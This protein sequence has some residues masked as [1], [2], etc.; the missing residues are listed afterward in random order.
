MQYA[1]ELPEE[2]SPTTPSEFRQFC[3]RSA[4]QKIGKNRRGEGMNTHDHEPSRELEARKNEK[5]MLPLLLLMFYCCVSDPSSK[6][7]LRDLQNAVDSGYLG[8][9]VLQCPEPFFGNTNYEVQFML[10][11]SIHPGPRVEFVD[12]F[13]FKR[14][15]SRIFQLF[16]VSDFEFSGVRCGAY[17]LLKWSRK[18]SAS[19]YS[20]QLRADSSIEKVSVR[21]A[22][23]SC[24]NLSFLVECLHHGTPPFLLS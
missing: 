2:V 22:I 11:V 10:L 15:I 17:A 18:R 12:H 5:K 9:P 6:G 1:A 19:R 7:L 4:L 14:R 8:N 13:A 20:D 3:I 16:S 24:M 23:G 21:Y